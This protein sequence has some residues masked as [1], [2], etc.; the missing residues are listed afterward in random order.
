MWEVPQQNGQEE[1][2]L[3][4]CKSA[5]ASACW[6]RLCECERLQEDEREECKRLQESTLEVARGRLRECDGMVASEVAHLLVLVAT[7]D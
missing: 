2:M 6:E 4:G 7:S 5:L 3:R 1:H